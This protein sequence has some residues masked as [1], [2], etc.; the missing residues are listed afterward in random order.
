VAEGLRIHGGLF[1]I[2]MDRY[3]TK[4]C[5]NQACIV[6]LNREHSRT[7]ATESSNPLD[8]QSNGSPSRFP[9]PGPRGTDV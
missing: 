9:F 8:I 6:Y 4:N 1:G 2:P 3:Q 5:E 7:V